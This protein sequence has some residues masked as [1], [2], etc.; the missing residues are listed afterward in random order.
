MAKTTPPKV[1]SIAGWKDR[2]AGDVRA[3]LPYENVPLLTRVEKQAALLRLIMSDDTLES[4]LDAMIRAAAVSRR[5][6]KIWYKG[7]S[8]SFAFVVK[9]MSAAQQ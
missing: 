8:S 2:S 1:A 3:R 7:R 6:N 5:S 9:T 4:E